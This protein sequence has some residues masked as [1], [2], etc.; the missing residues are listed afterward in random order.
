MN[1][2]NKLFIYLFLLGI[3]AII[4]GAYLKINGNPNSDY[5][6]GAGLV[7]EIVAIVGLVI[8]NLSKIKAIL[9]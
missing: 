3:F 8:N 4:N 6:L 5:T 7:M 9:R 2:K 1:K